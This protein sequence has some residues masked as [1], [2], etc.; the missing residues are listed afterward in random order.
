MYRVVQELLNNATKHS[1]ATKVKMV[2]NGNQEL[3][4]F[5]YADNGIGVDLSGIE[6]SFKHMGLAGIENRVLSLEGKFEIKSAL[7]NGFQVKIDIPTTLQQKGD[8][9]GNII[10]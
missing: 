3:I 4:Q 8:Q 6:G 9:Y 7:K 5:S 1:K 10:G 2:L